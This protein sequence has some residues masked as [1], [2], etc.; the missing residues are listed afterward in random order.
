MAKTKPFEENT[1]QYEQ[2]FSDNKF[3]YES[4]LRAIEHQLPDSSNGLEIGVGSGRFAAPLG[5]KTGVEPSE[6]MRQIAKKR[7]VQVVKGVAEKLPFPDS[8]FDFALMV[9][10]VCFVDDIQKSFEE[11]Y[12]VLKPA[13]NLIIGFI[14]RESIVG[15][16]YQKHKKNSVFYKVA[17]FYSVDELVSYLKKANFKDFQFSQTIF[18]ALSEINQIEPIKEGYGEGSFVIIKAHK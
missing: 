10:T 4:E 16:I 17:K 7:G 12:R 14:D 9:T 3:V 6:N 2:W 5:I 15:K 13:G 8:Q 18:Q 1:H 11:A